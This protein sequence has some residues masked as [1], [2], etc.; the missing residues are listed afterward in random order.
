[1]PTTTYELS[2][3]LGEVPVTVTERG[4]GDPVLLLHGGAGPVSVAGFAD[5]MA[6]RSRRRVLT[7][8]HPGFD[9][10]PRP[11]RLD[12]V[13]GLAEIYANLLD[14]LGLAAVT[15]VGSS[16]GGWVAAELALLAGERVRQVVLLDAVGLDSAEHPVVDFFSLTLDQVFDL[17]YADPEPYRIDPSTLTGAQ[18]AIAAGNRAALLAYGGRT[19]A[20]PGLAARLAGIAVPA[21][22][23]WGEA[24]RIA[25]PAYGKEY[26]AAIPGAGFH[27]MAGAGHLPQ[28]ETPDALLALLERFA[29]GSYAG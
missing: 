2:T 20:D 21:L 8:T 29:N 15:V 28:I 26:A 22:V 13:R 12:S 7:P 17:S 27:L 6:A 4:D 19:M 11:D 1:M 3:S 25:T 5:L 10:T 23:V 14:T 9:G 16:L 24:D 18:Q